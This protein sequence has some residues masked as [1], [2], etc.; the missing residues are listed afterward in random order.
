[1]QRLAAAYRSRMLVLVIVGALL[2]TGLC[3]LLPRQIMSLFMSANPE[4]AVSAFATCL[5][6]CWA[7]ISQ[8][9]H[10]RLYEVG[11]LK[12]TADGWVAL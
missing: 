3:L 9:T 6:V 4:M 7:R 5:K 12:S 1:M 2:L 11:Q 8:R 10:F